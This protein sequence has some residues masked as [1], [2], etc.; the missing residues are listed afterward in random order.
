MQITK[1]SRKMTAI[2]MTVSKQRRFWG[3]RGHPGTRPRTP[4]WG[5]FHLWDRAWRRNGFSH[6]WG[7][8]RTW[9]AAWQRQATLCVWQCSLL[10]SLPRKSYSTFQEVL[11]ERGWSRLTSAGQRQW[12][13]GCAEEALYVNLW[14]I[15]TGNEELSKVLNEA[16]I[17]IRLTEDYP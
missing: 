13:S 7:T 17:R 1:T 6:S 8:P 9:R 10:T 5:W 2:R 15:F 3:G 14:W 16:A 11:G 4:P 12:R